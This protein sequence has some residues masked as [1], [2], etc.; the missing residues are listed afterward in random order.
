MLTGCLHESVC[1]TCSELCC[2]FFFFLDCVQVQVLYDFTAEAG[3]N[4]LT[5]KEGETLTITN[6]VNLYHHTSNFLL[7]LS[8][9]TG[10]HW[11][12]DPAAYCCIFSCLF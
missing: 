4:E 9:L 10:W 11:V 6:Q 3:N 5:V 8:H 1:Q 7:S 2:V 12:Q